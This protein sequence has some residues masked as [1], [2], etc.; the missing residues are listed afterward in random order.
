MFTLHIGNV[1]LL[2]QSANLIKGG[3]RPQKIENHCLKKKD[4]DLNKLNST[5]QQF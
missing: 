2:V 4:G 3:T 1:L 5:K